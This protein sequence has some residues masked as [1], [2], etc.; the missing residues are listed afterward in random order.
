MNKEGFLAIGVPCHLWVRGLSKWGIPSITDML[1]D[2]SNH[3]RILKETEKQS[4]GGW[5]SW[6]R[7]YGWELRGG[8]R[9]SHTSRVLFWTP[10]PMSG[11]SISRPPNPSLACSRALRSITSS[12]RSREAALRACCALLSFNSSSS[13]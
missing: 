7:S 9:L 11:S 4:Q 3:S 12:M 1:S 13:S 6:R 10:S 5:R 8:E 2:G